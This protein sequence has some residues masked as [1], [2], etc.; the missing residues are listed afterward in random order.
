MLGVDA[1]NKQ[2]KAGTSRLTWITD[3]TLNF[4]C[5]Q[6]SASPPVT[7]RFV[8]PRNQR[9]EACLLRMRT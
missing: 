1:Q 6:K 8:H 7:V 2:G 9:F 3:S 5:L 4:G